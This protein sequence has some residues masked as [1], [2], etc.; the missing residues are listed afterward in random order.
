[1]QALLPHAIA[2]WQA[3]G[4]DGA[5][6]QR[7]KGVQLQIGNLGT[8]ILGLEAAN[9]ITI[10]QT[11]AGYNWYWEASPL[12]NL[13]AD[14]VDLLT[15]LEHELGHVVGLPDNAISDDLMNITLGLGLRRGPSGADMSMIARALNPTASAAATDS[16]WMGQ[17]AAVAGMPGARSQGSVLDGRQILAKMLAVAR[18]SFFAQYSVP[19]APVDAAI[20]SLLL[21]DADR[22]SQRN[23]D[24]PTPNWPLAG[25]LGD[26]KRQHLVSKACPATAD[27][28]LWALLNAIDERSP[29]ED[30]KEDLGSSL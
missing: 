3:A 8:S 12:A 4:L 18:E 2:A 13:A 24:L 10:N 21:S 19:S 9:V 5:G 22:D 23:N 17:A 26:N 7:L 30:P 15:V 27:G 1:L 20:P 25:V 16:A 14:R 11:A 6:V 28:S 29:A